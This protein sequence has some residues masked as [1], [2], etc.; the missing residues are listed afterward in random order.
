[1]TSSCPR[2]CQSHVGS[3]DTWSPGDR[4]GSRL[5]YVVIPRA[6]HSDGVRS[7]V[8]A[9]LRSGVTTYDHK[10]V[11]LQCQVALL[12]NVNRFHHRTAIDRLA[13]LTPE[14]Q[15]TCKAIFRSMPVVHAHVD[16]TIHC[17]ILEQHLQK[18]IHQHFRLNRRKK[19]KVHLSDNSYALVLHHRDA[20]R[21]LR[22][23]HKWRENTILIEVFQKW[24]QWRKNKVTTLAAPPCS[25]EQFDRTLR[26]IDVSIAKLAHAQHA[27]HC[28]LQSSLKLDTKQQSQDICDQLSKTPFS[29]LWETLKPLL[30]KHRRGLFSAEH[31]A[32]V[33]IKARQ[34]TLHKK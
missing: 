31:L 23:C 15:E 18:A 16:P 10:A 33:T 20:R 9:D 29:A 2:H 6:W 3:H 24:S 11:Q 26:N 4:P 12:G 17:N 8:D 32:F 28:Q 22:A 19:K 25:S 34:Q 13:M 5:D 1:M 21:Q 14:G 7:H 30:P 27:S